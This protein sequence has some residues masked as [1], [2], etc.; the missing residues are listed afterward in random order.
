VPDPARFQ[1]CSKSDIVSRSLIR[2][3]RVALRPSFEMRGYDAAIIP[4]DADLHALSNHHSDAMHEMRHTDETGP[5][6]AASAEFGFADLPVRP[7]RLRRELFEADVDRRKPDPADQQS[8]PGRVTTEAT[9]PAQSHPAIAKA[10]LVRRLPRRIHRATAARRAGSGVISSRG[11][12][13]RRFA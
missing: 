10:L 4:S 11:C 3:R 2:S 9:R 7:V 13:G 12:G 5:D 1:L 6:R 8:I